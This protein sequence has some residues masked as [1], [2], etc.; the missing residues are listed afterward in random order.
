[1]IPCG[2]RSVKEIQDFVSNYQNNKEINTGRGAELLVLQPSCKYCLTLT[3]FLGLPLKVRWAM[4][5]SK[6]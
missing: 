3:L 6:I 4:S 1:M 2:K 5:S